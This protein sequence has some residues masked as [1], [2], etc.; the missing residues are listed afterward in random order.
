MKSRG[1]RNTAQALRACTKAN[2]HNLAML[3]ELVSVIT[4]YVTIAAGLIQY[5]KE[6]D[7]RKVAEGLDLFFSFTQTVK[8][9]LA[10][11]ELRGVTSQEVEAK[12]E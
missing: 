1:Y 7:A 8:L 2:N 12:N 11:L 5:G 9:L 10:D 3:S 4:G 6:G